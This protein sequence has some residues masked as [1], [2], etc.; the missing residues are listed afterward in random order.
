MKVVNIHP[1]ILPIPPV[2]WGAVEKIIWNYTLELKKLGID[3]SF[4]YL[5]D[6]DPSEYDAVHCHVTNLATLA[7]ERGIEYFF[8]LHDHH[9]LFDYPNDAYLNETRSAIQNSIK[10]FV[11]TE[12][13]FTHPHFKDLSDK[14]IY[15]RHGVDVETYK[16]MN[17]NNINREGLLCVASNGFIGFK[18]FDRKGFL[19]AKQVAEH[20]K[21]PL[22]ICCP[23]NTKEF[24][25]Y[26]GFINDPN[27]TVYFD[28][29]ETELIEKYN[30]H[31]IFLHP[32]ILEAGHPNLTLVEAL[33]C[34][35]PVIGT[36]KGSIPLNGMCTVNDL[37][38]IS[39]VNA[40][41]HVLNN[42]EEYRMATQNNSEFQWINVV[43]NLLGYYKKYGY[44]LE[45]FKNV[46]HTTYKNSN[47]AVA[48]YQ[49]PPNKFHVTLDDSG[50]IK[51][52]ITGPENAIYSIKFIGVRKDGIEVTRYQT[53]IK[54][55][56]WSQTS[57]DNYVQWNVI[58][59]NELYNIYTIN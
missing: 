45:K 19:L 37:T 3:A 21:I 20:L 31:K 54:N 57:N 14:F 55:N 16:T 38:P 12:E 39:Y 10:T 26:Y 48:T 15:L 53:E 32:S 6:I 47:T 40:I 9:V 27:V 8:S 46:L 28:L 59:N 33:A 52:E 51:M 44:T 56:M 25:E 58:V 24:L 2:N 5:N 22:T 30:T 49:L 23:S 42:Y 18:Y 43:K 35:L 29:D 17:R 11:H 1:G 7:N 50:N 41:R 13:F 34:G 4:K 36:Y